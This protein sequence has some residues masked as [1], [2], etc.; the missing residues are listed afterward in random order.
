MED[1]GEG[2]LQRV[3]VL[4]TKSASDWSVNQSRLYGLDGASGFRC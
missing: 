4:L 2:P 1:G 3:R